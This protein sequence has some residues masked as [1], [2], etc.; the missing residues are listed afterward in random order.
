[1]AMTTAKRNQGQIFKG[2]ENMG[3]KI[4]ESRDPPIRPS[5]SFHVQA[6]YT[7]K[8]RDHV[9]I[10]GCNGWGYGWIESMYDGS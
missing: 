9:H 5:A 3:L 8:G 6:L 4:S 10:R 7:A 2:N 1:M